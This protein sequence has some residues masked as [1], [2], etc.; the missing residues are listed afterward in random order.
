MEAEDEELLVAAM[1]DLMPAVSCDDIAAA[2]EEDCEIKAIIDQ[3]PRR[4]PRS[5][6]ELSDTLKPFFKCRNELSTDHGLVFRGD[7]IVVPSSLRAQVTAS[8]HSTHPGIVRTKQ[9]LRAIFWWPG[10]DRQVEEAVRGCPTC[11]AVDKTSKTYRTPL[12]PV[13]LPSAPWEKVGVD[14][15]GPM[16]GPVSQRYGIVLVDYYS[17]WP[18]VAFVSEPSTD[19]VIDF[20]MTVASREGWPRELVSDNGTHFTSR[21][22]TSFLHEHGV[23][24]IRVTPYH[25][26]GA[27]AVERFNRSLK[28]SLQIAAQQG[29][30]RRRHTQQFLMV[31][32]ATPHA[33]T[34]RSPSDLLHG[35]QLRTE[36]E[37]AVAPSSSSAP[38]ADDS[39]VRERVCR[40]QRKMKEYHD[41]RSRKSQIKVGDLVRY[42]LMP[43][44]RKGQPQFSK[45]CL[46][47]A[48]RGP[49]SYE[50]EGGLRV[51]AE[52]LSSYHAPVCRSPIAEPPEPDRPSVPEPA[53]T[54][55]TGSPS[56]TSTST[57]STSTPSTST[58]STSTPSTSRYEYF[59]TSTSHSPPVLRP[60]AGAGA[61]PLPAAEWRGDDADVRGGPGLSENYRTRSG[62]EVRCPVRFGEEEKM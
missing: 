12:I 8:A 2:G 5:I 13:P 50:L 32:R 61:A 10:M 38:P 23:K 55:P 33:T 43:K 46:V 39:R 52:R 31:Y 14:F 54:L 62:R 56:D 42:R 22:F 18:E 30:D 60:R 45:P 15:I 40:K 53:P 17:K 36:L 4:W 27:G 20:L 59:T 48:Q 37:N 3:I 26:A 19:A 57:P 34:G 35:R 58:P 21:R 25:P 28:A 16:P 9:R 24:H 29:A 41:R 51:H 1:E 7:R 44:P 49:V 11:S 47:T 6:R